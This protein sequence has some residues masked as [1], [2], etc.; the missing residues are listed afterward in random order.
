MVRREKCFHAF[1]GFPR[2]LTFATGFPTSFHDDVAVCH[3]VST[4]FPTVCLPFHTGSA[5]SPIGTFRGTLPGTLSLSVVH[6][7][8]RPPPAWT[9]GPLAMPSSMGSP[10]AFPFCPTVFVVCSVTTKQQRGTDEA[11]PCR[12][13]CPICPCSYSR[14]GCHHSLSVSETTRIGR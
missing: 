6:R 11:K 4:F 8:L 13:F 5:F 10:R 12:A 2:F 7:E 9:D 14:C 3:R 1:S